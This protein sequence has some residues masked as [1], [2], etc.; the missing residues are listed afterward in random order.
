MQLL[1][2]TNCYALQT[3]DI[4]IFRRA[5]IRFVTTVQH[6]KNA[7]EIRYGFTLVTVLVS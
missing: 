2:V 1:T 4:R 7:I 6:L 3:S 5:C